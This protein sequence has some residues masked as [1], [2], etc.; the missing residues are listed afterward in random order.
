MSDAELRRIARRM[1]EQGISVTV[2]RAPGAAFRPHS[3]S[4]EIARVAREESIY[5][6]EETDE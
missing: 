4:D 6:E 5:H 3:P 1:K 2:N